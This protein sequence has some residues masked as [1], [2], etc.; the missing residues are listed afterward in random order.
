[1][2]T[3][4]L[5]LCILVTAQN[6]FGAACETYFKKSNIPTKKIQRILNCELISESNDSTNSMYLNHEQLC[7]TE[8]TSSS[9]AKNYT[10]LNFV[11]RGNNNLTVQVPHKAVS[12]QNDVLKI[13]D[14]EYV[15]NGGF[16]PL[17]F[18]KTAIII[19]NNGQ[20]RQNA[21]VQLTAGKRVGG[22]VE[23]V[24]AGDYKCKT[25][26]SVLGFFDL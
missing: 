26:N 21:S 20:A 2:K 11:I 6:A 22:N 24:F 10:S 19:S 1:M 25:A 4:L 5:T 12:L 23:V 3:T 13:T 9:D 8:Y 18:K 17:Y 14:L 16:L 7:M 15:T